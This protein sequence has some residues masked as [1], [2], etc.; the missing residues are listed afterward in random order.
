MKG[1]ALERRRA[2]EAARKEAARRAAGRRRTA[3]LAGSAVLVFALVAVVVVLQPAPPGFAYPDQGN[4]HL[5]ALDQPHAAYN[6]RPPS[7]GP[8]LPA[9]ADWGE[10]EVAIPPELY[11]H[12]LEDGGVILTYSCGSSCPGLVEGLR[13][14][15]REFD[16]R[17]LVMA[18]YDDIVDQNGVAR[19]AAAV[20]WGRVLYF[21]ELNEA[22][23]D[24]LETFI[25]TFEG[26]DHHVGA[27]NPFTG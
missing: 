15:L 11:V 21:D 27:S 17:R 7:S 9:L 6:S 12:N 26:V 4:L 3:L 16:G 22:T 2:E 23:R 18:P 20:A 10:S 25:H 14:T 19:R 1:R 13:S 8:H 24:D 5:D